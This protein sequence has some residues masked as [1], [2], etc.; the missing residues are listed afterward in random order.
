MPQMLCRSLRVVADQL[1]H[2]FVA[3]DLAHDGFEAV[4]VLLIQELIDVPVAHHRA[5][6]A[7]V[8]ARLL[9]PG[10]HVLAMLL[11]EV[12]RQL[13]QAGVQQVRVFDGLVVVIVLG[14]D[15]DDRRLDAQVDV[16]GHQRDARFGMFLLQGQRLT[17]DGV[18]GAVPG[19]ACRADHRTSTL[20]WKNSRPAIAFF[21]PL[22]YLLVGSSMPASIA[23][24]STPTISS[25]RKRLTCRTLRAASDRP[26]LP[27]SSSSSTIIGM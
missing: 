22:M 19:Q 5:V 15:A 11:P 9:L 3:V 16:L 10:V 20:V 4:R 17:E 25:S 26:F 6:H 14:V 7:I 27:A 23:D 8:S 13:L 21:W 24:L 18:V 2:R 1:E 12:G